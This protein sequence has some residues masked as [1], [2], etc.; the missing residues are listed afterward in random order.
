MLFYRQKIFNWRKESHLR[1]G[2]Q[3]CESFILL[4]SN[5]VLRMRKLGVNILSLFWI[6]ELWPCWHTLESRAR[7][8]DPE[9]IPP[10]Y[11]ACDEVFALS[12]WCL[13]PC[14]LINDSHLILN[15]TPTYQT[16]MTNYLPLVLMHQQMRLLP[17]RWRSRLG[18]Q[19]RWHADRRLRPRRGWQHLGALKDVWRSGQRS[20][21]VGGQRWRSSNEHSQRSSVFR[22]L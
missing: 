15:E 12:S 4:V 6:A 11:P 1:H 2:V 17:W 21:F 16:Y 13:A 9:T 14:A 8:V 10:H 5:F 18:L 3:G 22:G 7:I 20:G 19:Q